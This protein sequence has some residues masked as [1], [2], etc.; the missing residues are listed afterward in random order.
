MKKTYINPAMEVI[1]IANQ[2]QMMAG[3]PGVG[4]STDNPNDLL[5]PRMDDD[6]DW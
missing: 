5:S 2:T 3:S 1:K 4:G 6:F